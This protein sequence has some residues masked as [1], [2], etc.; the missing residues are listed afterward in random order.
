MERRKYLGV[1]NKDAIKKYH[2]RIIRVDENDMKGYASL[3]EIHLVKH[4]YMIMDT[5]KSDLFQTIR[6][7]AFRPYMI[8]TIRLLN[9]MLI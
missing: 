1:V 4:A 2:S 7:G 5:A 8:M 3:T 6:T 9:G